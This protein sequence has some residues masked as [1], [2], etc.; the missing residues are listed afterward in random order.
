LP[1]LAKRRVIFLRR[2]IS[3]Q[4]S[5]ILRGWQQKNDPAR[6]LKRISS[7]NRCQ[8]DIVKIIAAGRRQHSLVT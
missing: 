1:T 2:A 3:Y 4:L 7:N 6:R 8:P 5:A